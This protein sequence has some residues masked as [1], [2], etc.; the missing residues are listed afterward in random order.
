[1]SKP[2]TVNIPHQLGRLE[3]R[4][5]IDEGLGRLTQQLSG[6]ATAMVDH[7]WVGDRLSFSVTAMG[8]AVRGFVDVLDDEVRLEVLLP[9]FLAMLAG[10]VKGRLQKEGQLMLEKK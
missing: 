7:S 2:V 5:R 1:M 8:Q 10:K 6:G 4:R 3:A 9:G